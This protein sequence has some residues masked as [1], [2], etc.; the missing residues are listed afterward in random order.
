MWVLR[1][2][3]FFWIELD[4][5]PVKIGEGFPQI[6]EQTICLCGFDDDFV[7]IDLDIATDLLL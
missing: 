4:A 7:D 2:R 3:T 1:K 5:V 6:I